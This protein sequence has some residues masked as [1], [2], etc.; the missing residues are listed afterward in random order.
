VVSQA[1]ACFRSYGSK[2]VR[3][4]SARLWSL[5]ELQLASRATACPREWQQLKD[6][7]RSSFCK[8]LVAPRAPAYIKSYSLPK[9]MAAAQRSYVI[10]YGATAPTRRLSGCQPEGCRDL[11]AGR[12]SPRATACPREWQQLLDPTRSPL[13]ANITP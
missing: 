7:T 11:I 4:L 12:L 8:A 5:Q 10:S 2:I 13:I 3:D 9:R 6:R 1:T